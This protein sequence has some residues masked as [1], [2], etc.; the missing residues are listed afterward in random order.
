MPKLS[1]IIA[2]YN[3]EK[4]IERCIDSVLSQFDD[5]EII[6][7][8]DGSTDSTEKILDKYRDS[9]VIINLKVNSGC[10]AKVR[11]IGLENAEGEYITFLDADDWYSPDAA[12]EIL[13]CIEKYHPD[14]IRFGYMLIYEDGTVKK[15]RVQIGQNEFIEKTDFTKKVYPKFI[16]GIE[17][18]S[19]CLAVF[20]RKILGGI[21]FPENF[22]TAEDMAFS[23]EAYTRAENVVFAAKEIYC[24]YQSGSGLTGSGISVRQKY[25][26]NFFIS[27][28]IIKYLKCWGMNSFKWKIYAAF[29]PVRL[30]F[31]K[32]KRRNKR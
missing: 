15:P 6:V 12:S 11:N 3:A 24:Y 29:R 9:A 17:L 19:V 10:V 1:V 16:N 13:G 7:V 14:I 21:S 25:K 22:R 30:T 4:Y 31:D 2:A 28:R 18:N 32:L 23:L 27:A 8:N 26:Y 5:C 20:R